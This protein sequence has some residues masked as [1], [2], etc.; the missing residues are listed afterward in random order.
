MDPDL[1]SNC[2]QSLIADCKIRRCRERVNITILLLSTTEDK[3]NNAI[4]MT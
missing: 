3:I 1:G 2:L 4:I